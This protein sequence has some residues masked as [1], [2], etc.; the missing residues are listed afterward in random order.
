MR[1]LLDRKGNKIQ[2]TEGIVVK[3][4]E[5]FDQEVMRLLL[6]R[7]GNEVQITEGAVTA[8]ASNGEGVMRLLLGRRGGEVRITEESLMLIKRCIQRVRGY[9]VRRL[10]SSPAE[11]T[12]TDIYGRQTAALVLIVS[13]L[14]GH[15]GKTCPGEVL[16]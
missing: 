13:Q 16:A 9:F 6:N 5:S 14:G 3:I 10:S 7:R 12:G 8:A 11:K 2:I 4:A 1:L 15:S